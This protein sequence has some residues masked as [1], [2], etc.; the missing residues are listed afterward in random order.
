[1]EMTYSDIKLYIYSSPNKHWIRIE[2]NHKFSVFNSC[3]NT[4]A[5]AELWL[6]AVNSDIVAHS[7]LDSG[8]LFNF[9]VGWMVEQEMR[10]SKAQ[11]KKKPPN[12]NQ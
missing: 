6:C 9:R 1:M 5:T 10:S 8:P 12:F 4:F 3:K 2:N 11:V 7:I